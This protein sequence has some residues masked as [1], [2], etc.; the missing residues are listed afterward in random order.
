MLD[1]KTISKSERGLKKAHR[2][3]PTA[4]STLLIAATY[5]CHQP[6]HFQPE[7][8]SEGWFIR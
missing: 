8:P 2:F 7:T 5:R 6:N 3:A 1:L 4:S